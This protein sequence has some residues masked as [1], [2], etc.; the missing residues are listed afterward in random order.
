MPFKGL[1]Q[2]WLIFLYNREVLA[3]NRNILKHAISVV[4]IVLGLSL[5][6]SVLGQSPELPEDFTEVEL[7]DG[8]VLFSFSY[9]EEWAA[10][11]LESP[12]AAMQFA[13]DEE[14]LALE[15]IDSSGPPVLE[16]GQFA[17]GIFLADQ[18][19]FPNSD[20]LENDAS[21]ADT[22]AFAA[23][24]FEELSQDVEVCVFEVG[25]RPAAQIRTSIDLDGIRF[26]LLRLLVDMGIRDEMREFADLVALA[27]FGE[28]D[29]Y[30]QIFLDIAGTMELTEDGEP[31]VLDSA[32]STVELP[33]CE[34]E[35]EETQ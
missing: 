1:S 20:E 29:D 10:A 6:P 26:D 30:Q 34:F 28:M 16:A 2:R 4:C 18:R 7:E 11:E 21:I 17:V 8:R 24:I 23:A 15:L 5:V 12:F 27:G 19:Q 14:T 25:D 9:P 35:M 3:M 33:E 32:E 13:N 31:R 22:A